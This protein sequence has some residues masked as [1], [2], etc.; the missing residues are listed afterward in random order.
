VAGG[1]WSID[2]PEAATTSPPAMRWAR[3]EIPKKFRIWLSM[4]RGI[5]EAPGTRR[6]RPALVRFPTGSL[7]CPGR[8]RGPAGID[9]REQGAKPEQEFTDQ[10]GSEK[11]VHVLV[12]LTVRYEHGC[13]PAAAFISL[14]TSLAPCFNE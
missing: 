13:T 10:A 4:D 7:S 5:P 8:Q 11:S 3:I 1:A 9:Y 2:Q 6:L 14:S 12:V